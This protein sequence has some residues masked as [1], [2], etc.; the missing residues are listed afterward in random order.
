MNNA[1]VELGLN[2]CTDELERIIDLIDA[3]GKTSNAVPYLSKYAI[4]R[5]CGA[6]EQAFKA[7]VADFCIKRA[8]K[9]IKRYVNKRVRESSAN[10]SFDKICGMLGDFDG[11]WN[12]DFKAAVKANVNHE[13]L[14]NSLQSLVD[15]RNEFAHGGSPSVTM[16][17]VKAYFVDAKVIIEAL[18]SVI[19]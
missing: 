11:D 15:L 6:I 9:Q 5:A 8:R 13:K 2:S 3:L 7:V 10:P 12:K 4:I 19:V 17:D 14:K 16:K 1:D 18:D